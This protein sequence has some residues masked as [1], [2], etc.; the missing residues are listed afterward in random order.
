MEALV[1]TKNTTWKPIKINAKYHGNTTKAH[2]G[3][4]D[5]LRKHHKCT[6]KTWKHHMAVLSCVSIVSGVYARPC[7]FYGD[8]MVF[9]CG[10]RE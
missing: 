7:C 4:M 5:G 1:S 10:F 9:S 8:S 3:T 6:K 2:G